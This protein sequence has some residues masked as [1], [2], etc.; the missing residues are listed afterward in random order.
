MRALIICNHT[1][2]SWFLPHMLWRAGFI[3]DVISQTGLFKK[4]S[5]VNALF[6]V[7]FD[8]SVSEYAVNHIEKRPDDY[9]WIIVCEDHL[10]REILQVKTSDDLKLK[11]LPVMSVRD[12]AHI[13]SKTGLA[14]IFAA[15]G[16]PTPSFEIAYNV[17]ESIQAARRLSFPVF[18]KSDS[19]SA[20]R[21]VHECSDDDG[22]RNAYALAASQPVLIQKKAEGELVDLSAIFLEGNLVHFSYSRTVKVMGKFGPSIVR[23]YRPRN[24]VH[25]KIVLELQT[26]GKALGIHGFANISC[27]ES[28]DERFY[29]ETDL[30]PNVWHD[31]PNYLQDD[32]AENI[33][34]WFTKKTVIDPDHYGE[35]KKDYSSVRI[36][37]FLRLKKRELITNRYK[38]WRYVPMR[39]KKMMMHILALHFITHP[40]TLYIQ[41]I[42]TQKF[43]HAVRN[44]MVKQGIY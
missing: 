2:L 30:R 34:A 36:P 7:P 26:I 20:G 44:R 1:N 24:S 29:F 21:G 9:D 28:G 16:V 15:A 33:R 5:F 22:I 35:H 3:T 6:L 17:E 41:K 25:R 14:K 11:I 42:T 43:R 4:S 40:I 13:S 23:D 37:Y 12:F 38:A 18:L 8:H 32:P 31:Y 39:E 19:S 10:L 27:I